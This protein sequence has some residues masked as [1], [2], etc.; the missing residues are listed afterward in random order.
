MVVL[1]LTLISLGKTLISVCFLIV[2]MLSA[3][4]VPTYVRNISIGMA[5]MF[6]QIGSGIAPY[7]VDLLVICEPEYNQMNSILFW[8][9]RINWVIKHQK[10]NKLDIVIDCLW[11][12]FLNDGLR[13]DRK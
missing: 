1:N 7:I 3:E 11:C 9:I 8:N 6:A 2:F 13:F 12:Y 4:L 10:M 5:S